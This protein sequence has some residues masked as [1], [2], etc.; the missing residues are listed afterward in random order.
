MAEEPKELFTL[1]AKV[2]LAKLHLAAMTQ[3]RK[4]AIVVKNTAILDE[5]ENDVPEKPG[6]CTF[7]L[8]SGPEYEVAVFLNLEKYVPAYETLDKDYKKT[9]TSNQKLASDKIKEIEEKLDKEN[10]ERKKAT[11]QNIEKLKKNALKILKTYFENFCGKQNASKLSDSSIAMLPWSDVKKFDDVKVEKGKLAPPDE[12]AMNKKQEELV[13]QFKEDA[14]SKT[15]GLV[16]KEIE[17]TY[18]FKT[19]YTATFGK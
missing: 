14:K 13:K 8:E 4:D 15:E 10:E 17:V 5:G 6:K 1:D 2:L 3:V 19:G 11:E 16:A 12:A 9:V 7:D 18:C